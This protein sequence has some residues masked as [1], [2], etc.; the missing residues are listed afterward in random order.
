MEGANEAARR[1]T[2]AILDRTG[3]R[4]SRCAVWRL[5]EPAIFAPA[6][7]LDRARWMLFRR[8]AKTP[9]RV[10]DAGRLEPTGVLA[11]LIT[12]RPLAR[13]FARIAG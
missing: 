13:V 10:T 8:G 3:S 7:A 12:S 9:L 2:N 4:A 11:R 1:A 6:R 5:R